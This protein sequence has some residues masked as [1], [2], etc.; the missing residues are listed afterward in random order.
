MLANFPAFVIRNR[1]AY[2]LWRKG[3]DT[4]CKQMAWVVAPRMGRKTKFRIGIIQRVKKFKRRH[5]TTSTYHAIH[6]LAIRCL[7]GSCTIS[8]YSIWRRSFSYLQK[9]TIQQTKSPTKWKNVKATTIAATY[10]AGDIG[11]G[12]IEAVE[13]EKV[14]TNHQIAKAASS[15]VVGSKT[16]NRYSCLRERA[17]QL[18]WKK[19]Y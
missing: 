13:W 8:T 7:E 11:A 19:N 1:H 4:G 14:K 5:F 16:E 18:C 9:Y 2:T 17:Q 6:A 10:K 12:G 15:R 3:I